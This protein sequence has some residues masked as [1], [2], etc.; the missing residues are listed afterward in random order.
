MSQKGS[1]GGDF[2][3][4]TIARV[5]PRFARALIGSTLEGQT[6]FRDA[7]RMLGVAKTDTFNNLGRKVGVVA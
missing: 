2:Y 7:Y 6:L 1:S 4:T 5:S 3:R